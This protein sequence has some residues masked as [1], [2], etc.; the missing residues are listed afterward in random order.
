MRGFI[1]SRKLL[2]KILGFL[3]KPFFLI[4]DHLLKRENAFVIYRFGAAIGDQLAMSAAVRFLHIEHGL[5]V[6]VW[7][8]HTILF[9]NNPRVIK[10]SNLSWIPRILRTLMLRLT[11]MT[12][13]CRIKGFHLILKEGEIYEEKMRSCE[14]L[15]NKHIV[16]INTQQFGEYKVIGK[17]KPELF[18]SDHERGI[19][20][21]E[22]SPL[23]DGYGLIHSEGKNDWTPNKQWGAERF[24][25]L[26]NL[27]HDKVNWI[28]VGGKSDKKLNEAIDLRGKTSLR[29][30]AFLI[31]TSDYI[32][33][34]E[35]LY[36]HM[37]ESVGTKSI[38]IYTGFH[39]SSISLYDN[40]VP[41]Q[42]SDV[43]CAPCWLLTPCPHDMK[44]IAGQEPSLVSK[45]ILEL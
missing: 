31:E 24:Q 22:F 20:R 21:Q 38:T 29:G 25:E 4:W 35:G 33:C 9:H 28:Q 37:A 44:C 41:I 23:P 11:R 8:N 16:E 13:M 32:V 27:T 45:I 1:G 19:M 26:V 36:T 2:L 3:T 17:I 39:S 34:Q 12:G 30:L 7:C 40:T 5:N 15:K 43:E 10:C 18:L 6:Y 14:E 42:P